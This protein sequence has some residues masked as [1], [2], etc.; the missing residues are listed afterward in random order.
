[1]ASRASWAS[2]I[3]LTFAASF[4]ATAAYLHKVFAVGT[5]ADKY[6]SAS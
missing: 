5:L 4:A 1:M 2:R 3:Q 6:R